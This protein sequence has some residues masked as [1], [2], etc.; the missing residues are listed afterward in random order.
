MKTDI[1]NKIILD[2]KQ[3][4]DVI[5]YFTSKI[6]ISYIKAGMLDINSSISGEPLIMTAIFYNNIDLA[7]YLLKNKVN[8]NCINSKNKDVFYYL[9]EYGTDSMKDVFRKNNICF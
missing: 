3:M 5:S 2:N 7:D 1:L 9:K 4:K 6:C 8:L